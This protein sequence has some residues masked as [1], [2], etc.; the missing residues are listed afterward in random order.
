MFK[1]ISKASKAVQKAPFFETLNH[2]KNYL[3]AS[4]ANEG[5]RFISIPVFTYLLTVEDYGIINIFASYVSIFSIILVLNLHGAVSRYYYEEKEDFKQFLGLSISLVG[6]LFSFSVAGLLIFQKQ[7]SNWIELPVSVIPYFIPA[8]MMGIISSLFRQV[9]QARRETK[10]IRRISISQTYVGFALAVG[11]IL[12]QKDQLY[13]G[14]LKGDVAVF[15]I[16]GFLMMKDVLKYTSFKFKLNEEHFKY[17]VNYSLP[18]I[19]YL[20]SG[21]IVSQF[22]RIMINNINGSEEAGLYSFAYNIAT[23][24][25]MVSNSLHNAWTPK[26]YEYMNRANYQEMDRDSHRIIKLITFAL[27]VLIL[28]AKEIGALLSPSSYHTALNV[29][30]IILTGHFFIGLMPFNKNAI[31]YAKKTYITALTAIS[32]GVLNI[33]LNVIFIPKYGYVAAA[34]TTLA[35][36][37]YLYII[38]IIISRFA[39]KYHIFSPGKMKIEFLLLACT[40]LIYYLFFSKEAGFSFQDLFLKVLII[41]LGASIIFWKQKGK[42]ISIFKK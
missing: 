11:F 33:V 39:L 40:L 26:Y 1:R 12:L 18:N 25:I 2:S 41:G 29:I 23:L 32:T 31:L 13:L 22:D 36:Y 24:Q 42:I 27:I 4:I 10:K 30:P 28:F 8:V 17:I 21:I 7:I 34:Y 9:F 19:P 16:F 3:I 15:L 14:R 37:A 6:C 38:E 20:L 5:L 35:S